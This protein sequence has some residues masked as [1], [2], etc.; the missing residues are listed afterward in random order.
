MR[1][2]LE[3]SNDKIDIFHI[4]LIKRTDVNDI[5]RKVMVS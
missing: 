5:F 1:G 3:K 2:Y 4:L